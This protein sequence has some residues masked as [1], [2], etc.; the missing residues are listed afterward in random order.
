MN[1]RINESN[2]NETPLLR[3][4]VVEV[5][6]PA[7]VVVAVVESA[8]VPVVDKEVRPLFIPLVKLE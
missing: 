5:V 1:N 3:V 6:T 2:L 4:V 8:T 7:T